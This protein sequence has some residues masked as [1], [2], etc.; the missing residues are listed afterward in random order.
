MPNPDDILLPSLPVSLWS[1]FFRERRYVQLA[2]QRDLWINLQ[3]RD[4]RAKYETG[5]FDPDVD[6]EGNAAAHKQLR[7]NLLSSIAGSAL[8]ATG[9]TVISLC[10]ASYLKIP[11]VSAA[12]SVGL[13]AGAVGLWA[14]LIQLSTKGRS[15]TDVRLDE[16]LV[17][18]IV[19]LLVCV[20]AV[21]ALLAG[22]MA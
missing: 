11:P 1:L 14:G 8:L 12:K 13:A 6:R 19:K 16:V 15:W 21:L 18:A 20:A 7:R 9:C 22:V 10:I 2:L 5:E 4:L 3:A 17:G